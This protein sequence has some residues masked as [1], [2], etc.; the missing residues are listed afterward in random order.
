MVYNTIFKKLSVLILC[1]GVWV[2]I[3]AQSATTILGN[4]SA[5]SIIY[6][7]DSLSLDSFSQKQWR[8]SKKS[9]PK[10]FG[11]ILNF[12]PNNK[13]FVRLYQYSAGDSS[14]IQDTVGYKIKDGNICLAESKKVGDHSC[15]DIIDKTTLCIRFQN[16]EN[17]RCYLKKTF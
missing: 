1:L 8:A 10:N 16:L 4:Y 6:K 2:K 13:V 9:T 11:F 5:V 15:L 12:L 14:L 7:G 3:Y 17:S